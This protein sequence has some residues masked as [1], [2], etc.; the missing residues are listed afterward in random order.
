M[1]TKTYIAI[2]LTLTMCSAL[3][4]KIYLEQKIKNPDKPSSLLSILAFR[5]YG[6][7]S[8]LPMSIV[9]S[10]KAEKRLRLKANRA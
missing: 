8:L 6:M 10:D 2:F 5:R 3:V 9:C 7:M 1:N 4:Y